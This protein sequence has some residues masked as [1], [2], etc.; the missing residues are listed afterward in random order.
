MS[1]TLDQ[2]VGQLI[3]AG[4]RGD[5]VSDN[6]NIV[7]YI[8][9]YNLSGVILYDQDIE[10]N[11][12]GS[13]N[14]KSPAQLKILTDNL[15]SIS[16][17]PLFI[18]IDQEGGNVNRL[19][20]SYGFPEFPSWQ[21][22]GLLDNDLM[23]K[24]FAKSMSETMTRAGININFA[25]VLDLDYGSE[26]YIGKLERAFSGNPKKVI[27]HSK[28]FID[29]LKNDNIISCGKHFPGQG[30]AKG[31][32]HQGF[33]DISNTW[34]VADLLPY[35]ELIESKCLD[36]IMVSHVFNNKFDAELP[37]SLSHETI[38]S[39]LR[40]D[41][42]FQGV[43]I[44]DDPSMRAI[45]DNYEY[46]DM[47]VLMIN[48]GIDLLCLGNN[49]NFDPKCIPAAVNVIRNAVEKERIHIDRINES[50]KRINSLKKK[51]NLYE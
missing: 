30:S 49:L 13:R 7:R 51:Y 9:E 42:N 11:K 47:F 39:S 45:S 4:F 27:E 41:L 6:S 24:E 40:N 15:Q 48:A 37:A 31:D 1:K 19:H 21:H 43:I 28:I 33:I 12:L 22:I 10:K 46:E 35:T 3:I 26:T 32:T 16:D 23:T 25:P 5:K 17:N 36:M 34:S 8:K 44:C 20:S 14:I 50:I 38:T 2:L 29:T 18:S